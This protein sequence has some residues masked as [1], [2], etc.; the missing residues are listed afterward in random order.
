MNLLPP[1]ELADLWYLRYGYEWVKAK[2]LTPE[3]HAVA[4]LL[5]KASWLDYHMGVGTE[6]YFEVIQLK[7]ERHANRRKQG[8]GVTHA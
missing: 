4:D 8:T 1:Q 5:K 6:G 2:D 3:L 7:E